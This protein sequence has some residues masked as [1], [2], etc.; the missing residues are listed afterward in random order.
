MNG[1]SKSIS[2]IVIGVLLAAALIGGVAIL[3]QQGVLP[4]ITSSLSTKSSTTQPSTTTRTG[5]L[6]SGTLVLLLHDPP[7]APAGVSHVFVT[8]SDLAIHDANSLASSGWIDLGQTGT[9]DLMSVVNFTQTIATV[10]VGEGNFDL[11]R[12]NLSSIIITY[13]SQNYTASAPNNQLTIGIVGGLILSSSATAGTVIDITPTILMYNTSTSS[14]TPTFVMVPSAKA[15]VVPQNHLSQSVLQVGHKEDDS[16]NTWLTQDI[17]NQY[18]QSSFN[19]T[20]ASLSN[21][22]LSV[23]VNN[24]GNTSVFIQSIYI[25]P[26]VSQSGDHTEGSDFAS[27]VFT[28]LANGTL[29]PFGTSDSGNQQNIGYNLSAKSHVTFEYSGQIPPAFNYTKSSTGDNIQQ[30]SSDMGQLVQGANDET[31]TPTSTTTTIESTT[32]HSTT[33][34]SSSSHAIQIVSGQSYIIGVT[35]GDRT[36]TTIVSAS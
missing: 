22:S 5:V 1:K 17:T 8:Y 26:N 6:G 7:N 21:K 33:V 32:T 19:I 12:M 2:M 20:S 36:L 4:S 23:T 27:T 18:H 28:V 9:I 31:S 29:V 13:N 34:E 35:S 15:I 16:N 24:T 14:T 30:Q 25:G 3:Q 10:V 11:L